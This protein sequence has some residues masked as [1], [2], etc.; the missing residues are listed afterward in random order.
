[1][2]M[3]ALIGLIAIALFSVTSLDSMIAG[4]KRRSTQAVSAASS[5][6]NHFMALNIPVSNISESLRDQSRTS[7]IVIPKTILVDHKTYYTV[8]ATRCC[9]SLG[10]YLPINTIVIVS[11]GVY[12]KSGIV[13]SQYSLS[14]TVTYK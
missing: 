10:E 3:S 12:Q 4:N 8:E 11:T 1:M 9:N 14:A 13:I 6:L 5:G 2:M 7:K